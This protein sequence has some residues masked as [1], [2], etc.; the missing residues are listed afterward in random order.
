[1]HL[2]ELQVR[3]TAHYR[4]YSIH[5][6]SA[7]YFLYAVPLYCASDSPGFLGNN[8]DICYACMYV[9]IIGMT[10][11][12]R[13]FLSN[14]RHRFVFVLDLVLFYSRNQIFIRYM[15][16]LRVCMAATRF[17]AIDHLLLFS[18]FR[19]IDFLRIFSGNQMKSRFFLNRT[20]IRKNL[21]NISK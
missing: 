20:K 9:G 21:I 4:A 17:I 18:L 10:I 19:Q 2:N 15:Y 5:R 16:N 1:M 8:I 11:F 6:F 12:F 7:G 3:A 14:F 13:K